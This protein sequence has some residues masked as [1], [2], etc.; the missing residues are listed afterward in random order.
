MCGV[1]LWGRAVIHASVHTLWGGPSKPKPLASALK[2]HR[3]ILNRPLFDPKNLDLNATTLLRFLKENC[4]A[5]GS[6]YLLHREE[7]R[8]SASPD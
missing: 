8:A 7:A 6:T 4:R 5:E 3:P 1:G 2:R